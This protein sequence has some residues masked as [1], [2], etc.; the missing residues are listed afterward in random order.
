MIPKRM[1]RFRFSLRSLL[2]LM[3]GISIGYAL[4]L[5]TIQVLIGPANEASMRSLPNYIIEPPDVLGIQV[6][7]EILD[8]SPSVSGQHLVGPDG[9]IN[10][11]VHGQIYVTGKSIDQV[12]QAVEAALVGHIES[13]QVVVDVVAY[14]SKKCYIIEQGSGLG[15]S[16]SQLPITGNETALD[17]LAQI[18]GL[19]SPQTTKVWIARPS[20]S[21]VGGEQILPVQ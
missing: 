4:N 13:P 8:E 7:G 15:D 19:K 21:G 1:P 9:K 2:V 17:G 18:G 3:L 11:G 6:S 14:N 16:I 12:R 10:L 5:K 20:R